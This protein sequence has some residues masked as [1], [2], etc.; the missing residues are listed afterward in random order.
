MSDAIALHVNKTFLMHKN[1]D[2]K[3]AVLVPTT[4]YPQIYGEPGTVEATRLTDGKKRYIN[5]IPDSQPMAFNANYLKDDFDALRTLEKAGTLETYRLCFG[6][7]LG[8][9]GCWEW[10]GKISVRVEA[11]E[12]GARKMAFSITD[13]GENAITEVDPLTED[14][15]AAD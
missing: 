7:Q 1:A 2:G 14:Q 13:E 6:D 10:Q 4:N 8:T 9:D 12:S 3:W 15:L 11:G 5:D